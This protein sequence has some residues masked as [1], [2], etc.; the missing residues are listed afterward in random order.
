MKAKVTCDLTASGV[1]MTLTFSA[2]DGSLATELGTTVFLN[3]FLSRG[4]DGPVPVGVLLVPGRES[5]SFVENSEGG[6]M[7]VISRGGG[8]TELSAVSG[9]VRRIGSELE[10][11]AG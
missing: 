1:I 5:S 11:S 7:V 4:G 8:C 10:G 6:E 2:D 9:S 3:P